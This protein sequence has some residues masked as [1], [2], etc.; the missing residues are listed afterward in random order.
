MKRTANAV[1]A[2]AVFLCCEAALGQARKIETHTWRFDG[3]S[4]TDFEVEG[5][6][7][8]FAEEDGAVAAKTFGGKNGGWHGPRAS[9]RLT[10]EGDF[11]LATSIDFTPGGKALGDI[12]I[13]VELESGRVLS[14]SI[15]DAHP[16]SEHIVRFY[17]KEE[18]IWTTGY[19]KSG[20]A[21]SKYSVEMKRSS[22]KLSVFTQK[23]RRAVYELPDGSAV[24]KVFFTIRKSG[25]VPMV[26]EARI[27]ELSIRP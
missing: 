7:A 9:K 6:E 1:A 15:R 23:R 16:W 5:G 25:K 3:R 12:T 4:L 2:A 27:R 19:V 13:G 18:F 22:G 11:R 20:K 8:H 26:P 24:T 10:L 21:L 14:L 17:D